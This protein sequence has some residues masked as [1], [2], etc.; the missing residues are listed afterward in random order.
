[1]YQMTGDFP[2]ANPWP[3]AAG[4]S[5]LSAG[6]VWPP[7]SVRF[8]PILGWHP[9]SL[10]PLPPSVSVT[11]VWERGRVINMKN[12]VLTH[13]L[14]GFCLTGISVLVQTFTSE[15]FYVRKERKWRKQRNTQ[16]LSAYIPSDM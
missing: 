14:S 1:M 15:L 4:V 7:I 12:E 2:P 8:P 5:P 6:S 9:Q 16:F 3:A 11:R 10:S 13:S